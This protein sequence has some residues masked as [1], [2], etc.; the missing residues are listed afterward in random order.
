MLR[1]HSLLAHFVPFASSSHRLSLP[2]LFLLH[3]TA[4]SGSSFPCASGSR[5]VPLAAL[6]PLLADLPETDGS[7]EDARG[8]EDGP[9]EL[10]SSTEFSIFAVNDNPTPLQ[11]S[12]SVLL[13]GAIS[14]FLFRSLRRRAKRA[15]E[16]VSFF[17]SLS[18]SS[19]SCPDFRNSL[20]NRD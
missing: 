8:I 12:T 7:P 1:S 17:P 9:V 20:S 15:K 2:P 18:L 3:R 10:P 6:R 14:V 13:T 19:F 4:S 11:V 16:L 5:P